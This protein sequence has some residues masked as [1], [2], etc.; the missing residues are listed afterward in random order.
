M[1]ESKAHRELKT[2]ALRWLR[3]RGA[4]AVAQ[5]VRAPIPRWRFDAAGYFSDGAAT[6]AIEG[7]VTRGDFLRDAS[8][9]A[10]I[11]RQVELLFAQR[12][13]LEATIRIREPG[14]VEAKDLF[15]FSVRY[16]DST[17]AAYHR[18]VAALERR[19][20]L[21]DG[22][23]KFERLARYQVA[24][25]LY[26]AAP[27]GLLS[28]RDVPPGW[29]LLESPACGGDLRIAIEAP[30]LPA[31]VKHRTTLLAS[32]AAAAARDAYPP[33]GQRSLTAR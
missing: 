6:I 31:R 30:I 3:Q 24:D 9:L 11:D 22:S 8:T 19:L 26:L 5:E 32:I 27:A 14:L 12:S 18:V 7:K 4:L 2:A 25:Q 33:A 20:L 13:R 16:E 1:T 29:G 28:R 23:V 17:L 10:R 21:R 15:S